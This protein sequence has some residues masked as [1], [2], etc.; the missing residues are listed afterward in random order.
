MK[1]CNDSSRPT[2]SALI[3]LCL[4]WWNLN[5][6]NMTQC[7]NAFLSPALI[8][9]L[10][11]TLSSTYEASNILSSTPLLLLSFPITSIERGLYQY[12][13]RCKSLMHAINKQIPVRQTLYTVKNLI[14]LCHVLCYWKWVRSE[15]IRRDQQREWDDGKYS[16]VDPKERMIKDRRG[17]GAIVSGKVTGRL[18]SPASYHLNTCTDAG[19][20][21]TFNCPLMLKSLHVCVLP[22]FLFTWSELWGSREKD[23]GEEKN[24]T[25]KC[26]RQRLWQEAASQPLSEPVYL[27]GRVHPTRALV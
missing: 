20:K 23:E 14:S 8:F 13:T 6:S 10:L 26:S 21:S 7:K 17:G 2:D 16:R 27:T 1:I 3:F 15:E 9:P 22:V 12:V 19:S 4:L 5:Q 18:Y 11:F 24:Q 25:D